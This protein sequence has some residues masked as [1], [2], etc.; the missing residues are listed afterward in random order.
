VIRF[1]WRRV[2]SARAER[3]LERFDGSIENS[4]PWRDLVLRLSELRPDSDQLEAACLQA[5]RIFLGEIPAAVT[6]PKKPCV[7]ISH[8][9]HDS[10]KGER[11]AC[12]VE[13][14]AIDSWL[15]V[16]DPTLAL[17]NQLPSN[18]PRR[19]ALVAAIVEI[20]L[21]SSTHVI[22]LYTEHSAKSK[23]IPYE[24]GRAKTKKVASPQAA[25]W[26]AQGET[27]SSCGDYVLLTVVTDDE[28]GVAR[29]LAA[30]SGGGPHSAPVGA[31][32]GTHE[33]QALR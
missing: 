14:H 19:A 16:H 30:A 2:E 3:F 11:V 20:A 32:C 17:V 21:L 13:H 33:T 10:D 24:L 27:L 31:A 1:D 8:Q 7:F 29:W 4:R 28:P 18:D 23:W 15:D 12:L 26:L 9:R 5:V 6:P 22:A 25:I